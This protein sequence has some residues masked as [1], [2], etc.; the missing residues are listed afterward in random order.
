MVFPIQILLEGGGGALSSFV[1]ILSKSDGVITFFPLLSLCEGNPVVT[2]G[3]PSQQEQ[4]MDE[5][6]GT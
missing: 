4:V 6:I 1:L 5:R 2:G 3:F